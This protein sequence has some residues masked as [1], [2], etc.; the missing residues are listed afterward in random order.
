[1]TADGLLVVVVMMLAC[2]FRKK[3]CKR[4]ICKKSRSRLMIC[5]QEEV[6]QAG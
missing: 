3:S 6:K 2:E 4:R 5:S 1:M